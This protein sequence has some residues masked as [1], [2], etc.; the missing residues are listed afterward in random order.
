M[1]MYFWSVNQFP[2]NPGRWVSFVPLSPMVVEMGGMYCV[3]IAHYY[4]KQWL[5][6]ESKVT[7]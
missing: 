5:Q 4:F 7:F 1:Q 3:K 2:T 6:T